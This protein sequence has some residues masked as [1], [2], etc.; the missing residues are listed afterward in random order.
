VYA[1]CLFACAFGCKGPGE[2]EGHVP[3]EFAAA[4]DTLYSDS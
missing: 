3:H 4:E 2:N 1:C